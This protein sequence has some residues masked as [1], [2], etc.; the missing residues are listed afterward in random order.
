MSIGTALLA[1]VV[2]LVLVL[3]LQ[4]RAGVGKAPRPDLSLATEGELPML[5][6]AGRKIDAIKVYRRLHGV[7]LKAAKEA[8][9]RLEAEIEIAEH[10]A[11]G[12]TPRERH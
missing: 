11:R 1:V 6:R 10:R 7:D 8:I 12:P 2:L 5:V 9:D 4:S 3:W